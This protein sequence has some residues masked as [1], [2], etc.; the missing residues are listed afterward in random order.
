MDMTSLVITFIT[1][2]I[3]DGI[4]RKQLSALLT[5]NNIHFSHLTDTGTALKSTKM[6]ERLIDCIECL[7]DMFEV[8]SDEQ[9]YAIQDLVILCLYLML[10][11]SKLQDV[12]WV[13]ALTRTIGSLFSL[14]IFNH[15]AKE[16][17]TQIVPRLDMKNILHIIDCLPSTTDCWRHFKMALIKES[18]MRLNFKE[19][20]D[21]NVIK[22]KLE[23]V[24][25]DEG[26]HATIECDQFLTLRLVNGLIDILTDAQQQNWRCGEIGQIYRKNV[27][28]PLTLD[29]QK[30]EV[31]WSMSSHSFVLMINYLRI[32][33]SIKDLQSIG[34]LAQKVLR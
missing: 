33:C 1:V 3:N 29:E 19:F 7:P 34:H 5:S 4:E 17:A 10:E 13:K 30:L 28:I 18:L 8:D 16:I 31:S 27:S 22:D 6:F 2:L 26:T 21:F 11:K 24:L 14:P 25:A 20:Q 12:L 32:I 15:L 23:E 9:K